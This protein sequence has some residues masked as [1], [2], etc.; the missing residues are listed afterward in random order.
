MLAIDG[1]RYAAIAG[2]PAPTGI[3]GVCE[4]CGVTQICRSRLAGDVMVAVM[5]PSL[6]SQLLQGFTGV[7]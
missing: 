5:P 1:G 6:A 3:C 4:I 7:C 2:K